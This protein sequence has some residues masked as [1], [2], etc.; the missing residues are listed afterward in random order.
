MTSLGQGGSIPLCNVFA[1]VYPAAEVILMG[2]EEP[3]ARVHAP[4]GSVDPRA[5]AIMALTEALLLQH[6]PAAL[7]QKESG[8]RR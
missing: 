4:N 1:N 8:A 6:Y 2:V 5:I 3:L 7:Q